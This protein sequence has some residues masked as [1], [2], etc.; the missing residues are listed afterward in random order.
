MH[1]FIVDICIEN[2]PSVFT[3]TLPIYSISI[4]RLLTVKNIYYLSIQ[5]HSIRKKMNVFEIWST[6]QTTFLVFLFLFII[7]FL[8]II[9]KL[10]VK[11]NVYVSNI[12]YLIYNQ[13]KVL[14]HWSIDQNNLLIL[15]WKKKSTLFLL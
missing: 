5:H 6:D 2:N 8:S 7:S 1:T 14:Y 4:L 9:N 12:F 10:M 13:M 15:F 3:Q 11:Y